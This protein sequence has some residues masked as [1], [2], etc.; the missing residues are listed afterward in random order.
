DRGWVSI[1]CPTAG[2]AELSTDR[3]LVTSQI[4]G[5]STDFPRLIAPVEV[6]RASPEAVMSLDGTRFVDVV[7][8][9]PLEGNGRLHG[10]GRLGAVHRVLH[11]GLL[12][13]LEQRVVVERILVFVAV[14]G[15]LRVE[16]CVPLLQ[17][18]VILDD[19]RK[20][21]RCIYGHTPPLGELGP[22][23]RTAADCS[24]IG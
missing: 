2:R 5:K 13:G 24:G 12:L 3:K 23:R 6:A 21:R 8:A 16:L 4:R 20:K 22:F 18:E 9:G 10:N 19:L 15:Q 14:E 1:G 17:L 7:F 11:A